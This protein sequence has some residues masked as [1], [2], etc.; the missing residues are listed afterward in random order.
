MINDSSTGAN[1]TGLTIASSGVAIGRAVAVANSGT[2]TTTLGGDASLLSGTGSFTGAVALGRTTTLQ[3][4]GTSAVTFGGILSGSGGI[5]KSGTGAVVLSGI[6]TF[7]GVTTLNGGTLSVATI[8]N[9]GVAGNL[10][11]A[12]NAAANL[13]YNNGTLQYTGATASTNRNF[14]I[15]SGTTGTIDVTT[16]NLT[17]SGSSTATS[18]NLTKTGAGTLTLSGTN[19]YTGVTTLSN[20]TL[21]VATI[22]NGG[23]AGNLGNATNAAANLVFDGGTLQYTGA[24]A[25]TNRSFTINAG[26]TATF[27]VTAN[28][29]TLSGA[30]AATTGSLVKTGAGT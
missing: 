8:G 18:G 5:T 27:D 21:S 30:A 12:T 16:N 17:I 15:N 24:T 7:T 10:G 29:L 14:T 6:N 3:A 28:N 22:G 25:A 13:V 20:G 26:N 4:A 19:L 11:Q 1:A 2:G 9:G 23:V